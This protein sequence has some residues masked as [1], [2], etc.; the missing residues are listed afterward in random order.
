MHGNRLD[1]AQRLQ[2]NDADFLFL[3][4]YVAWFDGEREGALAFFRQSR[5]VALD[6]QW[7]DL[8]LKAGK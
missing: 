1:Q 6:P 7:A 5:A 3:C 8:F 2:A 4:G